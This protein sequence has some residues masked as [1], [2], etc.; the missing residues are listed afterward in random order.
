MLLTAG[1]L[2]LPE[3]L[4]DERLLNL[5]PELPTSGYSVVHRGSERGFLS[6]LSDEGAFRMAVQ[7]ARI[8]I[9]LVRTVHVCLIACMYDAFM[10]ALYLDV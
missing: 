7:A 8:L 1:R 6:Y 3:G 10:A 4:P 9:A 5:S 2:R